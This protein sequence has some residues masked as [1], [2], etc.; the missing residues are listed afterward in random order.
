M[1]A[2]TANV[3]PPDA[4]GMLKLV[5]TLSRTVEQ[6]LLGGLTAG[7]GVSHAERIGDAV[8]GEGQVARLLAELRVQI[9]GEGIVALNQGLEV[10][11]GRRY[12]ALLLGQTKWGR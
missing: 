10:A 2:A 12:L 4:P 8:W 6:L 1:S 9:E 3:L 5:Q 11:Q 7:A